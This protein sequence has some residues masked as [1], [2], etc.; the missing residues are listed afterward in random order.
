MKVIYLVLLLQIITFLGCSNKT[1]LNKNYES[2]QITVDPKKAISN[3]PLSKLFFDIDYI[4]LETSQEHLIGEIGQLLI[5][6]DNFY[7]LDIQ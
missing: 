2:I 3:L 1:S 7:I 4:P 5:Y 6:Q